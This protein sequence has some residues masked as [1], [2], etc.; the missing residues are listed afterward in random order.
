MCNSY[1]ASAWNL[2]TGIDANNKERYGS[3]YWVKT[4]DL[5]SFEELATADTFV[6]APAMAPGVSATLLG[7]F[8]IE[9]D[10]AVFDDGLIVESCAFSSLPYLDVF[11]P[12]YLCFAEA[13][14]A[15]S[16]R[17]N[18]RIFAETG[19]LP[20]SLLNPLVVFEL[21]DFI[22]GRSRLSRF[23]LDEEGIH[24]WTPNP[25][26]ATLQQ[27]NPS[28]SLHFAGAVLLSR[29]LKDYQGQLHFDLPQPP[30]NS[31]GST[32]LQDLILARSENDFYCFN[33][34]SGRVFSLGIDMYRAALT[35]FNPEI[36]VEIPGDSLPEGLRE[37]AL[38]TFK[39]KVCA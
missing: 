19:Q 6:F 5:S 23:T 33:L 10:E 11:A 18:T 29:L 12:T 30:L 8:G 9:G 15:E 3:I 17:K 39:T 38:A 14:D 22:P 28:L 34:D 16:L 21:A 7:S 37:D 2:F 4:F 13:A 32:E 24:P 27:E 31:D 26:I 35:G 1:H 20:N 25:I 36:L